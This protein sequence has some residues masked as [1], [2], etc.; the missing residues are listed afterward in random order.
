MLKS[1]QDRRKSPRVRALWLST[2]VAQAHLLQTAAGG[3]EV[4]EVGPPT[5]VVAHLWGPLMHLVLWNSP[6]FVSGEEVWPAKLPL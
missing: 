5:F 3:T 1:R 4:T 2:G 6:V